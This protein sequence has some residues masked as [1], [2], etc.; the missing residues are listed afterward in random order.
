[1]Q[2]CMFCVFNGV[3]RLAMA[4]GF[5]LR[6]PLPTCGVARNSSHILLTW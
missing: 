6:T 1:M 2:A 4:H 5:R 3:I